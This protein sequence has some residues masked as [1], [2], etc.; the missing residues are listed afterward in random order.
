M[1]GDSRE[2]LILKFAGDRVALCTSS[3]RRD[4]AVP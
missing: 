2:T 3:R 1:M 4:P